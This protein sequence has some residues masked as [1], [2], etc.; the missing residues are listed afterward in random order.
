MICKA[1]G[2][3]NIGRWRKPAA[4]LFPACDDIGVG[5]AFTGAP[6]PACPMTFSA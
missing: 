5:L 1:H 6:N 3:T 4:V 2:L